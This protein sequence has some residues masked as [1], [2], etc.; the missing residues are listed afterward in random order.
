MGKRRS[1]ECPKCGS[2]HYERGEIRAAGGFW[3]KIFDLQNRR[4]LSL[5]CRGCGYTEFYRARSSALG[6]VADL[7]LGQ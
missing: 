7:V 2:T 1:F 3:S 6:D 4:F 5:T